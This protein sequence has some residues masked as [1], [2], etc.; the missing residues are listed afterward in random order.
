MTSSSTSSRPR[1]RG[2][3]A[4][5]CARPGSARGRRSRRC[6]TAPAVVTVEPVDPNA[7]E[8]GGF[9]F[10]AIL[11]LYGQLIGI[12]LLRRHRGGRGEE[13]RAWWRSLLSTIR[14]RAPAGRQGDRSRAARARAA[15]A[16]RGDR[17]R[18]GRGD[19]RARRRR[20]LL[21][22]AGLA[23]VWFV[24]GYAFYACAFACAASLVSRQE[25]LQSVITPLTLVLL[26]SFFVS[27]AVVERP[28][29]H[30]RPGLV[31]HPDDRADDA[32]RRGSRWARRARVEIVARARGDARRARPLLIPLAAR[33][34]CGAVSAHGLRDEAARRLARRPRLSLT[35]SV[36]CGGRSSPV[37]AATSASTCTR[38]ARTRSAIPSR[39]RRAPPRSPPSRS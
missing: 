33:I 14:P 32:C 28:G 9:A 2:P 37:P 4:A 7:D 18:G 35:T 20:R 15:A 1:T 11:L 22:A 8:R 26:V 23:L 16:D 17:A 25:D 34:Y 31:V 12:R 27:F 19:R 29:R 38:C 24:V 30:A 21:G 39:I 5:R 36:P 3:R 13:P 6:A 10:F